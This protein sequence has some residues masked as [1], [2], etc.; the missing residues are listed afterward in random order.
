[1]AEDEPRRADGEPIS[2]VVRY[3]DAAELIG[4]YGANL[5]A[6]GAFVHTTREL[7]LDGPI[8]LVLSFPGLRAPLEVDGIVRWIRGGAPDERGVGI[9]F[10]PTDE[11]GRVRLAEVVDALRRGEV[12][13]LVQRVVRILV[14]EDNPYVARFIE[15]GLRGARFRDV[16]FEFAVSND[17][18]AALA[19]VAGPPFD[20]AIIDMYLPI[21]D[22]AHLIAHS[23]RDARSARLPILAVSAGGPPARDAALG[24]GAD[25]FLDKPMRLREI[26]ESMA[27]LVGLRPA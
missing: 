7:P 2:L 21:L 6:G 23:R 4:D 12:D 15:E 18:R 13:G 25:V 9:E 14:V 16:A 27:S 17:G 3:A 11:P 8:R 26:V 10:G 22:G 19:A 5:S 1:M 24:A 20:V